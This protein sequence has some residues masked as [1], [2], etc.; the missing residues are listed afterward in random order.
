MKKPKL[1]IVEPTPTTADNPASAEATSIP[2]PGAFDLNQFKSKRQPTIAGVAT[3]LT[4]LPHHNIA[5][6]NDWTRLHPDE[7]NYWSAEL[8]FVNV[9]IKGQKKDLV[10]LIV[11]DIAV[12][13]LPSNRIKQFRL[14]LASKPNDVFF[15]CHVPTQN[16]DNSFNE[17]A[18]QACE[19]A[20][21]QWVQATSRKGEGVDSYKIDFA[22]DRDAFAEPSWP[23]QS[24]DELIGVTFAGR[25]IASENDP[26]LLRLIGA[27]QVI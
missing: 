12:Q 13:Y 14:A 4:A 23:K 22:R 20:K 1:G 10:H 15:L 2:K 3:L 9:P 27:K 6:A 18:L 11:Q 16:L 25:T 8:C 24:L 19:L 17:T 5:Q 26:G 21:T 7:A